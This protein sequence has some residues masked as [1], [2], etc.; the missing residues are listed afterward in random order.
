MVKRPLALA[1]AVV[2]G[3]AHVIRHLRN[4]ATASHAKRH[5]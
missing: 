2:C 4:A 3:H 5:A 1:R